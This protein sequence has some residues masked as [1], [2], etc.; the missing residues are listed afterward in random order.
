[1]A[2]RVLTPSLR[3]LSQCSHPNLAVAFPVAG[4]TSSATA[5]VIDVASLPMDVAILLL[6][7]QLEVLGH[8][9]LIEQLQHEELRRGPR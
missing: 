4:P 9:P 5:M 8:S 3:S 7:V 2:P 6:S 1:M